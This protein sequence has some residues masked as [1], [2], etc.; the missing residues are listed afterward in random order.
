MGR[1]NISDDLFISGKWSGKEMA[2]KDQSQMKKV[3]LSGEQMA[4]QAYNSHSSLSTG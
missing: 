1:I 3:S 4:V 2:E